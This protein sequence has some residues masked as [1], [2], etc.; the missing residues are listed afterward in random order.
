[1][2]N[3]HSWIVCAATA[4]IVTPLVNSVVGVL[5]AAAQEATTISGAI[6]AVKVVRSE[7][8]SV[9]NH[10]ASTQFLDLP[11]ASTTITVPANTRAHILARFSA[12]SSCGGSGYCDVRILINGLETEPDNVVPI[13]KYSD[14][15]AFDSRS[16]DRSSRVPLGPGVYTVKVQ[17]R[18]ASENDGSSFALT[19]WSLTVER[20]KV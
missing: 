16:I 6:T 4:T 5:P 8:Y 7:G 14:G 2:K 11:G 19:N 3:W 20:V 17:Y 12:A 9:I 1:M 15:G 10:N 18:N 13:F